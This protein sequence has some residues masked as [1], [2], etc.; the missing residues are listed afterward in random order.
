[1]KDSVDTE[2]IK[3]AVIFLRYAVEHNSAHAEELAELLDTLPEQLKRKFLLAIGSFEAAN[4]ELE[5]VLL[6]LEE[7]IVA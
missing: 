5:N 2:S 3:R 7:Y 6:E 4:V 1:M